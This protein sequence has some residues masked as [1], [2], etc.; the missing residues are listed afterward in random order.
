MSAIIGG[1]INAITRL[2]CVSVGTQVRIAFTSVRIHSLVL[3][4]RAIICHTSRYEAYILGQSEKM[5][6]NEPG[7]RKTGTTD[8]V[9]ETQG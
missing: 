3:G 4:L 6:W 9:V 5:R 8:H 2:L 7:T 1:D